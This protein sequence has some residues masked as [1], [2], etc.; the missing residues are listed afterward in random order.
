MTIARR[1][2]AAVALVA[3]TRAGALVEAPM[4]LPQAPRDS[5]PPRAPLFP[6][7]PSLDAA[8]VKDAAFEQETWTGASD[9]QQHCREWGARP[10]REN[11]L[12]DAIN[13]LLAPRGVHWPD[14]SRANNVVIYLGAYVA[15]VVP[16][17]PLVKLVVCTEGVAPASAHDA[18][19]ARLLASPRA[20]HVPELTALGDP[21]A[22][23]KRVHST[24]QVEMGFRWPHPDDAAAARAIAAVAAARD[25]RFTARMHGVDLWWTG[26][27]E[28]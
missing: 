17:G 27:V 24:G 16:R 18:F 3:C 9:W 14:K 13:A 7:D 8:A 6:E 20:P 12:R 25:P 19:A 15:G 26:Q 1:A 11:E 23:W 5:S 2:L 21:D 22:A 4:A 28:P 10:A